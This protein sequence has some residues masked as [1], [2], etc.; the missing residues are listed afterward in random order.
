MSMSPERTTIAPVTSSPEALIRLDAPSPSMGRAVLPHR[1][2]VW[3]ANAGAATAGTGKYPGKSRLRAAR[4]PH[5]PGRLAIDL[6]AEEARPARPQQPDHR[7][8][9]R[10]SAV[11]EGH[12]EPPKLLRKPRPQALSDL[13]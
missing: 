13:V 9:R 12:S 2:P 6:R 3:G 10:P 11:P 7:S 5:G 1:R 4:P 8:D